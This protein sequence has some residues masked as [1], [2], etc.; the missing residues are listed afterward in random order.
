MKGIAFKDRVTVQVFA[1]NGGDGCRSFRREKFV[2]KGGPDGG[3]GGNG[4]SVYFVASHDV[5]SLVSLYYQPIQRARHG[6]RGRG[7]QQ[8]GESGGD[9]Y[10]P[11]PCGTEVYQ[12]ESEAT[13]ASAEP[14]DMP[15]MIDF[16]AEGDDMEEAPGPEGVFLGEVVKDGDTLLVAKGGRGGRGN[17]NF[18]TASHQAPT[19]FTEGTK[20]EIKQLRLELK[21]V[22]D[23]G[24]VGYPNAGK[25]TLLSAIS[26]ARPKIASYPFTTLNPIIGT[27]MYE[28]YTS[29][30]V[31][32]I[33]GLIDGAHLG[34]GLG[35]DFLRHIERSTYLLFVVDMAGVDGRDPV[36]D[37]ENLRKE[38]VLYRE[39]LEHRPFLVVANKMDLPAAADNLKRFEKKTKLRTFPISAADGTGVAELKQELYLWKRGR[40]AYQGK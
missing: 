30:R 5:D 21:T 1:G 36:E 13:G 22:A 35:H 18:A 32:D 16:E 33:P 31:A 24:L 25:S 19:E 28:D 3:D 29:L 20:G 17:Q 27:V 26:H 14:P 9:L 4:G 8:T 2:D 10:I 40:T 34:V 12:L 38:V 11:V 23:V 37:Y 7:A 15:A 39:E 6:G